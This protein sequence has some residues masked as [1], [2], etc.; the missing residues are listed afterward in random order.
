MRPAQG[1][2]LPHEIFAARQRTRGNKLRS[3]TLPAPVRHFEIFAAR[4]RN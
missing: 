4:L 1:A 3:L 2:A